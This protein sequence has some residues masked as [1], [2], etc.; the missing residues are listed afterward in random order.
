MSDIKAVKLCTQAPQD[1]HACTRGARYVT[2]DPRENKRVYAKS[3][4]ECIAAAGHR[5]VYMAKLVCN[6]HKDEGA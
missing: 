5:S 6:M 4:A 3:V 2:V 1:H